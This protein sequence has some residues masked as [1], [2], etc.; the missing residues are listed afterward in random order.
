MSGLSK[1]RIDLTQYPDM[2]VS[3][4]VLW[5]KSLGNS[6]YCLQNIPC[7]ALGYGEGDIVR[8][9][10]VNGSLT[11]RSLE[12]DRGNG[13]IRIYCRE[14]DPNWK[15][16]ALRLQQF[17]CTYEQA[18]ENLFLFSVPPAAAG[19][20]KTISE[21]LNDAQEVEAWEIAK[22]PLTDR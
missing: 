18:S 21:F 5:A 11:V 10:D 4:E 19:Y 6:L 7:F 16:V 15:H 2:P 14:T 9:E 20:L 8:C 17:G 3:G 13:V 12:V 22:M 1:I